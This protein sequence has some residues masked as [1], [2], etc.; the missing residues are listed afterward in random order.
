[1]C[2]ASAQKTWSLSDCLVHALNNNIQIQKAELTAESSEVDVKQSRAALFPQ[3][4]FQTS[5]QLGFQKVETQSYSSFD[6]KVVNPTYTGSY[7]V[8]M[9]VTLYDGLSNINQLKQSRLQHQS[10]LYSAQMTANNVQQQIIQSYYQILYAH[11][12]VLTNEEIVA[13]ASRELERTLAKLEVGKCSKLDVAQMESQYQQNMYQ[14]VNARNQEQ[15]DIL[16]LKQLLQLDTDADFAIDYRSFS[17]DDVLAL[18]PSVAEAQQMALDYLPE[19]RSAEL[20][21][22]TA[23]LQAR[24][25]KAG[26]QPTVSL[27]A[28]VTTSN[29]NTYTG[30][31]TQQVK[32]HLH[33]SVG[34]SVSVPLW[35]GRRTR[36]SVDKAKLQQSNAALAQEDTRLQVCNTIASLHLDILSAQARYESAVTKEASARESFEL[37][38]QRYN[39]GLESVVDLLTEKNNYLQARQETLQSKFTALLNLRLMDFYTGR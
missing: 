7:G 19:M 5:Q 39:I 6:A 20:G 28:G 2:D 3:L 37:M 17:D 22:Q 32:D 26:Y 31:F 23:D 14:L 21:V 8:N 25:A 29:G 33:E 9:N 15:A 4:T 38:E 1:M 12:S 24:I 30:D 36:S 11:E 18:T 10:D 27:N 35:D 34:L 16:S 13:V